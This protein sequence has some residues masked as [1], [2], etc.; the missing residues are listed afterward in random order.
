MLVARPLDSPLSKIS[1]VA[2]GRKLTPLC[3]LAAFVRSF[4]VDAGGRRCT[5]AVARAALL[6]EAA[7]TLLSASAVDSHRVYMEKCH[8]GTTSSFLLGTGWDE[9][10][11]L[12]CLLLFASRIRDEK[13]CVFCSFCPS[14]YGQY[15]FSYTNKSMFFFLCS[16]WSPVIWWYNLGSDY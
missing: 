11:L 12:P 4:M 7:W 6:G 1:P 9:G 5:T 16:L 3:M 14:P 13:G 15:S 10:T 2:V 8:R